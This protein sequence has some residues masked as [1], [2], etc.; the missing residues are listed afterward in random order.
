MIMGGDYASLDACV[1]DFRKRQIVGAGEQCPPCPFTWS[2][3]PLSYHAPS[4]RVY[5][6][7]SPLALAA[8]ELHG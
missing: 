8:D 6:S 4:L 7:P 5:L 1:E 3:M 2:N